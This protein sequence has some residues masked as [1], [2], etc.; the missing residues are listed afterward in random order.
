MARPTTRRRPRLEKRAEVLAAVGAD[1]V[2]D[3]GKL[4]AG[5]GPHRLH[6]T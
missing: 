2:S 5:F 1:D 4:V 6:T 3:G